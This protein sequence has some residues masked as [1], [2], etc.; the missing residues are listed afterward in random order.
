M[1]DRY[2]V[3]FVVPGTSETRLGIVEQ[4][5]EE[6]K[7]YAQQGKLVIADAIL[8][9]VYAVADNS[10][11]ID[12]PLGGFKDAVWDEELKMR[13]PTDEYHQFVYGAMKEALRLSDSLPEG[14][15]VGKLFGI[16]V[17][18]GTAWYVITEIGKRN[19][20]VEWRGFCLD[21]WTD[22]HFG[23]GGSFP[24]KDIERYVARAEGL[25]KIFGKKKS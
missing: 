14:L 4:Y 24:K 3:K 25:A 13:V 5:S 21:R 18:D 19:C 12:I 15:Q 23:W 8:P 7:R 11:V 10:D 17:G 6:A 1:R 20:R 22:H 16:G 9:K 2:Q